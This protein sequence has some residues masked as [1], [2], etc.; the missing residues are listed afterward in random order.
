MTIHEKVK[1]LLALR[2]KIN[3]ITE[4]LE[5]LRLQRD[6]TQADIIKHMTRQGFRS[7]KTEN[8]T[9]AKATRKRL[10]IQNEK[11]LIADLKSKGLNDYVREQIDKDLFKGFAIE[12]IKSGNLPVGTSVE[13]TEYISIRTIN[14]KDERK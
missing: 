12:A 6:E 13:E 5:P 10:V 1:N 3:A 11:D 4:Q 8:T 14:K 2:D 9:V 7:V